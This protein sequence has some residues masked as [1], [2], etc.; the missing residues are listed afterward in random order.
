MEN[1]VSRR[2]FLKSA[3]LSA[4]A[5]TVAAPAP[6]EAAGPKHAT[7]PGAT[8][9]PIVGLAKFEEM[10][11][12]TPVR[13]DYPDAASPCVAIKMATPAPGGVGP[14]NTVVAFSILCAHMGC[15]VAFDAVART[16]KCPCH[17]SI[18]DPEKSGQM[19]C[20]QATANLPQIALCYDATTDIVS[21]TGVSGLIYGRVA[22]II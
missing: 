11:T 6:S 13:F 18:F 3:T 17:F 5:G 4:A 14:D 19:V 7:P 22:N 16:F 9:Y 20:G 10:R 21:A 1:K 2:I 8:A 15:P 12:H